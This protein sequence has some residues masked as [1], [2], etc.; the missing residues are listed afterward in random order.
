M[1]EFHREVPGFLMRLEGNPWIPQRPP[2]RWALFSA[3]KN[4]QRDS[5][6]A[7][8]AHSRQ[9]SP[10]QRD[11]KRQVSGSKT[12]HNP[13][14]GPKPDSDEKQGHTQTRM[15]HKKSGNMANRGLKQSRM[16]IPLPGGPRLRGNTLPRIPGCQRY[17]SGTVVPQ[18]A[19]SLFPPSKEAQRG[20]FPGAKQ[21]LIPYPD[22]NQTPM[23]NRDTQKHE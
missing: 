7:P 13:S 3:S 1:R 2:A 21:N 11:L 6:Q 14:P 22:P 23:K 16:G 18:H 8:A 5:S 12:E 17:P 4:P 19:G 20:R 15:R 10:T 9:Q